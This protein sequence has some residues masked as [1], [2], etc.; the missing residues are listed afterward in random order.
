MFGRLTP[1][2]RLRR[3]V[4]DVL[5]GAGCSEAYSWSMVGEDAH[6][7]AIELPEPLSAD[8]R[9]LRTEL[10][11]SLVAF[12]R[13][14]HELGFEDVALFEIARVYAP[15]AE[16]LPDESWHV[17]GVVV[18]DDDERAFYRAKG[19]VETLLAELEVEPR[20]ERGAGGEAVL[21]FGSVRSLGDGLA[22]FELDLDALLARVPG[23]PLYEDVITY[24]AVKQDLAFVVAE[25]VAAG[26]LVDAAREAAGPELRAMRVFDV[27]RGDQAGPGRKSL[28][29]R[30]EFQSPERTLTDEDAAGLRDR[31]VR[32]LADRFGAQLRA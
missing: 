21:D 17:A 7:D 19:I 25:G 26:D 28:A 8:Q 10:V 13:H 32:A 11:P 24:P 31:I 12:A 3:T 1:A 29:F 30:V 27:Y 5:V 15:G 16:R 6:P 18:A 2:Q 23:L 14:N 22:G 4:E 20:F 9:L